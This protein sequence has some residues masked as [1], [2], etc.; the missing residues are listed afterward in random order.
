MYE[1]EEDEKKTIIN[2]LRDCQSAQDFMN[3]MEQ[4]V[5]NTGLVSKKIPQ[6]PITK[7]EELPVFQQKKT[8]PEEI[9]NVYKR[10]NKNIMYNEYYIE[11]LGKNLGQTKE[12]FLL[13]GR[14]SME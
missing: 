11:I 2:Y 12:Y 10:I 14:E 1:Q 8:Y 13:E 9:I 6:I 5:Q 4:N 3:K 7:D